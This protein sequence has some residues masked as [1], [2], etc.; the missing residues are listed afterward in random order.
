MPNARTIIEAETELNAN[1]ADAAL[2]FAENVVGRYH[3]PVNWAKLSN[4]EARVAAWIATQPEYYGTPVDEV[5]G[6]LDWLAQTQQV[7]TR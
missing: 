2:D 6:Y 4:K 7:W 3:Y 5:I 1:V